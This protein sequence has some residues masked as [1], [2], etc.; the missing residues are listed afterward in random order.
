M[1]L[2]LRLKRPSIN[3][4]DRIV[5]IPEERGSNSRGGQSNKIGWL[6][7]HFFFHHEVT[8]AS[9]RLFF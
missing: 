9:R 7:G 4:R 2:S 1:E 6:V 5:T 8:R 3:V